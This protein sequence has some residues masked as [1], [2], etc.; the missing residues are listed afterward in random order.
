MIV[1]PAWLW[2]GTRL[3]FGLWLFNR[4]GTWTGSFF[5]WKRFRSRR[6]IWVWLMLINFLSLGALGLLF[7]WLHLRAVAH[8]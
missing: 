1:W 8:L 6:R 7:Y 2:I 4:L 5:F 3:K